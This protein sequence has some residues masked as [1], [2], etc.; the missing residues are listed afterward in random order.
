MLKT[1]KAVLTQEYPST[2]NISESTSR[3]VPELED[4]TTLPDGWERKV[5][6]TGLVYYVDHN[7]KSTSWAPPGREGNNTLLPDGWEKRM[8]PTGRVYYVDHNSKSTSWTAP[9]LGG[10]ADGKVSNKKGDEHPDSLTSMANLGLLKEADET[11]AEEMLRQASALL[12]ADPVSDWLRNSPHFQQLRQLLQQTPSM[13][14]PALQQVAE[15]NPQLAQWIEQNQEQFLELL[16][17]VP[18][19]LLSPLMNLH[20][21]R[22]HRTSAV[23]MRA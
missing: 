5:T 18:Y 23:T 1:E 13:V 4:D 22:T 8:T 3:S 14:E 6:P 17:E 10:V 9:E 15:A 7:S 2:G 21:D 11:Q 12:H 16:S 20:S 19:Q